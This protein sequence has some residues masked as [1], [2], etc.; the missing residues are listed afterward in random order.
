[1][2]ERCVCCGEIIP[3]GQQVCPGCEKGKRKMAELKPKKTLSTLYGVMENKLKPCPF[4]GKPPFE[5]YYDRLI[6]IGC[7]DCGYRRP[8]DG[9]ISTKPSKV[10][11]SPEGAKIIEYYHADAHEKAIEAWN[12][13]AEDGK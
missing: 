6:V 9:L 10:V 7:N 1:M 2:A 5:N 13:R 8:F 4:C 11:A 3:E 12:R